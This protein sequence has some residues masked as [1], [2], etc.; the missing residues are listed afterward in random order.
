MSEHGK[1]IELF[2]QLIDQQNKLDARLPLWHV[3][4]DHISFLV[5]DVISILDSASYEMSI[6][7]IIQSVSMY[8]N[9]NYSLK[10]LPIHL[11]LL[12]NFIRDTVILYVNQHSSKLINRSDVEKIYL[13]YSMEFTMFDE[14]QK[15]EIITVVYDYID[16]IQQKE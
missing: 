16:V 15:S 13:S 3:L 5:G 10:K 12:G 9:G 7:Q 8:A 11:I 2:E 6:N 14:Q 1:H 4:Y